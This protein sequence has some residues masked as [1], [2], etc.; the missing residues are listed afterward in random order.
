MIEVLAGL[1]AALLLHV[2]FRAVSTNWPLSYVALSD[3]FELRVAANPARYVL[4]RFAPVLVV[5]TALATFVGEADGNRVLAVSIA[6]SVH[7][8]SG[9]G[10]AVVSV[11]RSKAA[12]ARSSLLAAYGVAAALILASGASGVWL[13]T[14]RVSSLVP[15][16]ATLLESLW[17]AVLAAVLGA[18]IVT[19]TRQDQT[20][21]CDLLD[22]SRGNLPPELIA[23]ARQEAA[24]HGA[25]PILVQAILHA[26]NLQRPAW[27]RRLERVK[28]LLL[29]RGT[30]GVMQMAADEPISDEESIRRAVVRLAGIVIPAMEYGGADYDILET[31]IKDYNSNPRYVEL[32]RD[33]YYELHD[34]EPVGGSS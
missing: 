22:R 3:M 7:V 17:T 21:V 2:F 15:D 33:L 14:T 8:A 26:E 9:I 30:Y 10:R 4:F 23:L 24:T 27:T 11:V 19:V 29:P 1:L 31:T 5:S 25:D 12:F 28:G 6:T 34:P 18:Y 32:V 13:S 20:S 16:V